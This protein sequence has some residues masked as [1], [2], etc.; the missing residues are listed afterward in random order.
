MQ[1]LSV[2]YVSSKVAY[3][4]LVGLYNPFLTQEWLLKLSAN[5]MNSRK[6]VT[7]A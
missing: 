6:A 2:I 1:S 5:L 7:G 4:T 3:T